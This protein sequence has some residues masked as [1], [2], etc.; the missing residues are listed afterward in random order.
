MQSWGHDLMI[1]WTLSS[2]LSLVSRSKRDL[3]QLSLPMPFS[4]P[5]VSWQAQSPV[6]SSF[7]RV[8]DGSANPSLFFWLLKKRLGIVTFLQDKLLRTNL[9]FG[10]QPWRT[11]YVCL[12]AQNREYTLL[13]KTFL[14]FSCFTFASICW[15]LQGTSTVLGSG[16]VEIKC[17]RNALNIQKS[18]AS[19]KPQLVGRH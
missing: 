3:C 6:C 15:V 8:L 1:V 16:H 9:D 10:W 18:L 2:F 5:S 13:D 19:R 7:W 4:Q 12:N 17:W 14:S 11:S